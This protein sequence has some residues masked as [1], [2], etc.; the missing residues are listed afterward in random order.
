MTTARINDST[1]MSRPQWWKIWKVPQPRGAAGMMATMGR[2][3]AQTA[4]E[5]QR[6]GPSSNAFDDDEYFSCRM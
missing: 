6:V 4:K 2:A 3:V 1:V 5:R